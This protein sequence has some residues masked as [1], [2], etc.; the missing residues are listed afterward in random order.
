MLVTKEPFPLYKLFKF[1]FIT[2]S[3]IYTLRALLWYAIGIALQLRTARKQQEHLQRKVSMSANLSGCAN[4][5]WLIKHFKQYWAIFSDES[6]KTV[7][8]STRFISREPYVIN[9]C[10]A[11]FP[12]ETSWQ[13]LVI[14][15]LSMNELKDN[16]LFCSGFLLLI[17]H[18]RTLSLP[19]ESKPFHLIPGLIKILDSIN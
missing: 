3:G 17:S 16:L 5:S 13:L 7:L 2:P 12:T 11:Y 10:C 14:S 18:T 8:T 1:S 15:F 4:E 6:V 9:I 19:K